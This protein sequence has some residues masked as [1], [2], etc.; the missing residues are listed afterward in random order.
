MASAPKSVPVYKKKREDNIIPLQTESNN[1][2]RKL[3]SRN[4]F[5]IEEVNIGSLSWNTLGNVVAFKKITYRFSKGDVHKNHMNKISFD[6]LSVHR[7]SCCVTSKMKNPHD[8]ISLKLRGGKIH[9][10]IR[11]YSW[12]MVTKNWLNDSVAL[13]KKHYIEVLKSAVF[14]VVNTIFAFSLSLFFFLNGKHLG[15]SPAFP[16]LPNPTF[17]PLWSIKS[18][19]WQL[20]CWIDGPQTGGRSTGGCV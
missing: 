14:S 9:A 19:F 12:I 4:R 16:S 8:K 18:S 10:P 15:T 1:P 13:K 3:Q 7:K 5:Q 2:S 17:W 11:K 6:F 20:S